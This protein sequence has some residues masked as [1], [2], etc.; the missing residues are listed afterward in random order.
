MARRAVTQCAILPIAA[1]Q[2]AWLCVF[3]R[4]FPRG[5][6]MRSC[7]AV[8]RTIV[9]MERSYVTAAFFRHRTYERYRA[10]Q[11]QQQAARLLGEGAVTLRA[12]CAC[13]KC[14]WACASTVLRFVWRAIL[15]SASSEGRL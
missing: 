9:C 14:A 12:K 3:G 8:A 10:L 4:P 15:V 11:Q 7:G 6:T 13:S 1:Q 2:A 5:F